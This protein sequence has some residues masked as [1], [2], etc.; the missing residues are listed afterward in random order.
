M[1]LNRMKKGKK[2]ICVALAALMVGSFIAYDANVGQ[3]KAAVFAFGN[4]KSSSTYDVAHEISV[5]S[6]NLR[7]PQDK[8]GVENTILKRDA[9]ITQLLEKYDTDIKC[10][11]ECTYEWKVRLDSKLN[12]WRYRGVFMFNNKGL[13]NP[14]YYKPS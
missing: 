1:N 8:D 12:P 11:Q 6:Q 4:S 5:L 14:I 2:F 9:R 13:C 7:A 3:S 10:F